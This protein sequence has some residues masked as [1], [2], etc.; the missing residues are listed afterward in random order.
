LIHLEQNTVR[1]GSLGQ[2]RDLGVWVELGLKTHGKD[3]GLW[4]ELGLK[5]NSCNPLISL[6]KETH[7][8]SE[9]RR[10]ELLSPQSSLVLDRTG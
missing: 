3:S 5:T 1:I 6:C 9:K 10:A 7:C 2:G 4:V 8:Y